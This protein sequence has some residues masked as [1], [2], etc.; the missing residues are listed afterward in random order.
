MIYP[1]GKTIHQNLSAEYTDVPQLLSTLKANGFSGVVEI[2]TVD[3]K[4]VFFVAAG[5]V[6]N[7]AIGIDSDPPAKVGDEALSELFI[8]AKQSQ[9][10]LHVFELT[11]AEIEL[12]TGPLKSELLFQDLSTDFIRMD[13]FVIKLN[14]EKH[15]GYIEIFNKE[16]KQ[17]GTLSFREGEVVGLK[18][19]SSSGQTSLFER[20]AVEPALEEAVKDGAV[21]NVY[22]SQG[23]SEQAKR[24]GT[25]ANGSGRP[26]AMREPA[27][28]A[29]KPA[30]EPMEV[31]EPTAA[32]EPAVTREPAAVKE[33]A[34]GSKEFTLE[35]RKPPMDA[36]AAM[37]RASA[38]PREEPRPAREA[39]PAE[40]KK[41]DEGVENIRGEFLSALQRILVKIEQ[42]VDDSTRKGTFQKCF[43]EARVDRSE[44]HHFL[45]PFEGVFAYDS[46]KIRLED[47]VG[48][49]MFAL[50]MAECL[51]MT[52]SNIQ[53]DHL[54]GKA[55]PPGMKGEIE[56]AFRY[57]KEMIKNTGLQSVV[58]PNMR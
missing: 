5:Q 1:Q 28:E 51:N 41:A 2:E 31:K 10:V 8:L 39:A 50:A 22:R 58:P 27:A 19:I 54:K 55:L 29:K 13:Q 56:S 16:K 18:L 17:I 49:E 38:E 12:A 34:Y 9:G 52:L 25:G 46:G 32:K 4:G 15:T 53:K 7:A 24:A 33:P 3:K 47:S 57:H 30:K 40:G 14:N 42:F 45:D 36:A 23:L 44:L 43:M 20:E 35:P 26:S 6:V 11:T 48:T 37:N 21:F